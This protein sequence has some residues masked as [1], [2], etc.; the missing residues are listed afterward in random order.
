MINVAELVQVLKDLYHVSPQ[1]SLFQRE[2]VE[3]LESLFIG[4]RP[5]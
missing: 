5:Q 3:S 2:E 1:S 4:L